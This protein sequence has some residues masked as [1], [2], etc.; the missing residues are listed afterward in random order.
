MLNVRV[1]CCVLVFNSL[2]GVLLDTSYKR[3]KEIKTYTLWIINHALCSIIT[4]SENIKRFPTTINLL[5]LY[6]LKM[7]SHHLEGK[8]PCH[9]FS[10]LACWTLSNIFCWLNIDFYT[11]LE[12]HEKCFLE[13]YYARRSRCPVSSRRFLF[14]VLR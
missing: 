9:V 1:K 2:G 6:S 7:L 14:S 4:D 10:I 5:S 12:H 11:F 3:F 13:S 8:Y